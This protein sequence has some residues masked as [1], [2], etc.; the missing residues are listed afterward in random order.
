[1]HERTDHH[2]G[3]GTPLFARRRTLL[4]E[5]GLRSRVWALRHTL[6]TALLRVFKAPGSHSVATILLSLDCNP[7]PCSII[8]YYCNLSSNAF[9]NAQKAEFYLLRDSFRAVA[10]DRWTNSRKKKKGREPLV[11][12]RSQDEN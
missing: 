2:V 1:M 7:S 3:F 9:G 11:A 10:G 8:P 6:V 12:V 4:A 5:A